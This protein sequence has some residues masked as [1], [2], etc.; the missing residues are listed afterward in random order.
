MRNDR[1]WLLGGALFAVVIVAFGYYF[2]IA[3]KKADTASIRDS[4][5]NTE[6]ENAGKRKEL[7]DLAKQYA[8][9][10]QYK[11]KLAND[12]A[13]LPADDAAA[14]LLRELQKAGELAGVTVSGVS[15]GTAV[16]LKPTVGYEMYALPVSLNVAG[17]TVK[18]N[19]FLDQLQQ[20]QPRAMLISSV[21]FAPSSSTSLDKAV[22]TIN[23]EAFYAPQA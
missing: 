6:I 12:Q 18:M 11:A 15:V 3:P 21:N 2:L 4:A 14:D 9:I 16:D 20:V 13:A 17:P 8:N 19:P 23:L 10:E 1:L 7:A 22:V 5:A